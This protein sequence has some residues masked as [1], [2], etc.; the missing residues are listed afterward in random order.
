MRPRKDVRHVIADD[1]GFSLME[2]LIS[3]AIMSLVAIGLFLTYEVN[4]STYSRGEAQAAVQQSSRVGIDLMSADLV[5]AGSGVP[6]ADTP[7]TIDI[8]YHNNAD[9]LTN[10]TNVTFLA[11]IDDGSALV[12]SCPAANQITVP[13]L[14]RYD[15][16]IAGVFS[17]VI[18]TDGTQWAITQV[19]GYVQDV[20][21]NT[22]TITHNG[23]PFV[24]P[25]A[26]PPLVVSTPEVIRYSRD[27]LNNQLLRQVGMIQPPGAGTPIAGGNLSVVWSGQQEVVADN[28]A[29]LSFSYFDANN[30][31]MNLPPTPPSNIRRV[32]VTFQAQGGAVMG[33]KSP[34]QFN[35]GMNARLRTL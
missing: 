17:Y 14:R 33:K 21:T 35:T 22:T 32:E 31:L 7:S 23:I 16:A 12:T 18:V 19:L 5:V 25:P 28:V 6:S 24:C 1:R 30:A 10:G 2:L 13:R 20:A 9:L 15:S 27:S 3:T 34:E 8:F 11:D 26:G 4:R 29:S